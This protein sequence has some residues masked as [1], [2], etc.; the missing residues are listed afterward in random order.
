MLDVSLSLLSPGAPKTRHFQAIIDSVPSRC[1]F[2]RDAV[3]L[4]HP[5]VTEGYGLVLLEAMAHALP[6]IAVA[7]AGPAE[8]IRHEKE[9]SAGAGPRPKRVSVGDESSPRGSSPRQSS[10]RTG[11]SRRLLRE[12]LT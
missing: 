11:G 9:R 4:V 6:V 1:M 10:A 3:A 8:I 2:D 12:A 5:A 7:A